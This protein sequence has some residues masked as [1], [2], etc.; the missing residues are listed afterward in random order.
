[1][2]GPR[3]RRDVLLG[4]ALDGFAHRG[5]DGTTVAELA[6]ATGMSKAAVS[7][8]FPTKNDLLHALADPLLDDLDALIERYPPAPT[9]PDQVRALLEDYLTTLTEHRQVAA[10]LDSDKAVLNHPEIGARLHRNTNRM[11]RAITGST[12]DSTAAAARATA[13]L[14]SLWHPVRALTAI[15]LAAHR[16]ALIHT[17]MAGCAPIH[18]RPDTPHTPT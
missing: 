12:T 9:W 13:A 1:V 4:A 11:R 3:N 15:Q 14:G 2:P 8:H 18:T 16:D 7:Y 10:W 5:Y 17:A 6:A